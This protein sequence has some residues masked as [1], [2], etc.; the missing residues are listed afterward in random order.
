M[1]RD[2]TDTEKPKAKRSFKD[3]FLGDYDYVQLCLPQLNPWSKSKSRE[4]PFYGPNELL[5][6][7]LACVMGFQHS[8]SMVGGII[9]PPVL[10]GLSDTS[11]GK[12]Y[13]QAL[14]SSGLIMSGLCSILQVVR[15]KIPFTKYFIGSGLLSVMG[16]SF[17]FL[18]IAQ[19]AVAAQMNDP[20]NPVDFPT[21]YGGLLGCFMIGSFVELL[22]SF[23]PPRILRKV[24]P[25]WI[26]GLTIFLIGASLIGS[27]VKA[28]G[29]G[30]FCADNPS[31]DCRVGFSTLPYGS[32]VYIGLGFF[33]MVCT[34]VLELF[35]SPF[36]RSCQVAIALLLGYVLAASTSDS[37]GNRYVSTQGM[38]DAPAVTFL[39]VTYFPISLY[40]PA[41]LPVIIGFVVS[42]VESIG[43]LTASG[44]A[45]GLDPDSMEQTVAVQGGLLGDSTSSFLAALAFSMPNTTFSQ[46]NGVISLTRV[47][48]RLAGIGCAVWLLIYG[49]FGK[50]GAFFTSIPQPVLGGMTTFLFANITVSGIKVITS[51]PLTRRIRFILAVSLAFGL[52]VTIVPSWMG[53]LLQCDAIANGGVRGLCEGAKLT[54]TTGYAI[55]CIAALLLH[56]IIPGDREGEDNE[57]PSPLDIEG[58]GT[59]FT[60]YGAND[61]AH[62]GGGALVQLTD[63][64]SSNN[65]VL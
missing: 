55:G 60:K 16:T 11:E 44:E 46:N 56:A 13:Q 2:D 7:L 33:V 39:W 31:A 9:T 4:L 14:V 6:V 30:T 19:G 18:P 41:L 34:L 62:S 12:I 63:S 28:W 53:N 10:V 24:F 40:A 37:E 21:A 29:G 3:I 25:P 8:L 20:E 27:G 52:G 36:M 42:G 38:Q 5:P 1:H 23:I 61:T 43:D 54:I 48:S 15:L 65:P 57:G 32:P 17:T 58:N 47:A 45:S 59:S 64:K 22:M 35:G 50:I 26:S 49:I 51:K